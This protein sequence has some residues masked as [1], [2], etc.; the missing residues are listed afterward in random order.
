MKLLRAALLAPWLFC[1]SSAA[2]AAPPAGL[3]RIGFLG[4]GSSSTASVGALEK[5]LH[6][7]GYENGKTLAVEKRFAEGKLE[8]LDDLAG[9]L[10]Q[11]EVELIV[12]E[13]VSAG[14]A[15]KRQTR[16]IPIVVASRLEA[17]APAGN[18]TGANNL[19]ADLGAA[20]LKLLKEISPRLTRAALLWHEVNPMGA[21]YL[22]K[23]RRAAEAADVGIEQHKV[24]SSGQFQAAFDAMAAEKDNGLLV[25][26]QLLFAGRWPE[27]AGLALRGRLAAVSGMEEF[28]AAGGLASY[29]IGPAEMWRHSALLIDRIFNLRKPKAGQALVLPAAQPEKFELAINLKTA[30]Q[31]GIA[32]PPDVLKR[33]DRVIR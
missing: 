17:L 5:A 24:R 19:S 27:I 11:Q 15:A 22:K 29:G 2:A 1:L 13:G 28:A 7:K 30:G 9:E 4:E 10:V 25:E 12:A 6:E 20:R 18:V 31:L 8:R 33:A 23:V 21:A 14:Q 3:H 32:V 26:P 16:K